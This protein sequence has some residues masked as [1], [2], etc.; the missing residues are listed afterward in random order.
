MR[1]PIDRRPQEKKKRSTCNQPG[2]FRAAATPLIW[3]VL[4][5]LQHPP[6]ANYKAR[7]R[8]SSKVPHGDIGIF[9]RILISS[10]RLIF[11]SRARYNKCRVCMKLLHTLC[12]IILIYYSVHFPRRTRKRGVT[13]A[14]K[15]LRVA[16]LDDIS[17]LHFPPPDRHFSDDTFTASRAVWTG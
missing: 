1:L 13:R 17:R 8:T 6:T 7:D 5:L 16:S 4:Q 10:A 2:R 11:I 12:L 14:L 3:F 9:P 15:D